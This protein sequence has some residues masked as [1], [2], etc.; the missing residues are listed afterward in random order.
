MWDLSEEWLY[1]ICWLLHKTKINN[2]LFNMSYSSFN[3]C[4]SALCGAYLICTTNQQIQERLLKKKKIEKQ[5]IELSW[6]LI[7]I[8]EFQG[9]L[10]R[11]RLPLK[12]KHFRHTGNAY[13]WNQW[14]VLSPVMWD[15]WPAGKAPAAVRLKES[16][17]SYELYLHQKASGPVLN[18]QRFGR[19]MRAEA[20]GKDAF[21]FYSFFLALF[22]SLF[23]FFSYIYHL[24]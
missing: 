2:E 11:H 19:K 16:I 22:F 5:K 8:R 23:L 13:S 18:H 4:M 3:F 20:G 17:W 10:W 9:L 12:L 14:S 7:P 1:L 6:L 15:E 24:L 21:L